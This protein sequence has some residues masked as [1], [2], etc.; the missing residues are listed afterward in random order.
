MREETKQ[1]KFKF[2]DKVMLSHQK[3]PFEIHGISLYEDSF[4]YSIFRVNECCHFKKENELSLYQ[5]P[6]KKK[7]Y[8]YKR[9]G[10]FI[11]ADFECDNLSDH[12]GRIH[13][14]CPEYDIEYPDSCKQ[15]KSTGVR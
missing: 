1:P 11:F 2:G 15:Q 3:D 14:P 12:E 9:S 5:E 8:A 6:K 13:L 10:R 7:L 4:L